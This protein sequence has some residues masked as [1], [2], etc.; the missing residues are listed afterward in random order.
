MGEVGTVGKGEVSDLSEARQGSKQK[1][2]GGINFVLPPLI[3]CHTKAMA[4]MNR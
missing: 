4:T 1:I 2:F 3:V